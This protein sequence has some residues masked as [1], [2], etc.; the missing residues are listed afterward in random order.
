MVRNGGPLR[1]LRPT[2]EMAGA[3]AYSKAC[4]VSPKGE[5]KFVSKGKVTWT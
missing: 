5:L 2:R 4:E 3:V 1:H